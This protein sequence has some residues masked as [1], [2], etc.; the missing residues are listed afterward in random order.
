MHLRAA[1][2]V[3]LLAACQAESRVPTE[4]LRAVP[5]VGGQRVADARA[6]LESEGFTVLVVEEDATPDPNDLDGSPTGTCSEGVVVSQDP[7]DDEEVLRGATV[8]LY[9]RGCPSG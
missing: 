6:V 1:L 7:G 8:T 4:Q 3:V 5:S 9:A 2:F